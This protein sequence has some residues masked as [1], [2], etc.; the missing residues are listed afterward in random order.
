[1]KAKRILSFIL[2]S[3]CLLTLIAPSVGAMTITVP[4]Y[5]NI[6]LGK[7]YTTP[8][9]YTENPPR[10]DY[11][12]VDGKELTDGLLGEGSDYGNDWLGFTVALTGGR[13]HVLTIDMGE[14][15]SGITRLNIVAQDNSGSG[16]G[17]PSKIEY[18]VSND[19]VTYTKL[20]NAEI[21]KTTANYNCE[22]ILN[23]PVSG[24]YFRANV[25]HSNNFFVFISEFE[26]CQPDGTQE[27]EV[28][29]G[30][31]ETIRLVGNSTMF[32]D[33]DGDLRGGAQKMT[34]EDFSRNFTGGLNNITIVTADGKER[35]S[36]YVS[37]G[38][39]AIKKLDGKETD[40][41]TIIID[42]DVNGDG[43]IN[44]IDYIMVKRQVVGTYTIP[45]KSFKAAA[46]SD[47]SKVQTVDYIKVKRH[48]LN[49]YNIASQYERKAIFY[50]EDMTFTKVSDVLYRMDTTYQGKAYSQTFDKK[51]DYT[52]ESSYSGKNWGSWNIG[53]STYNGKALAGGGTD[54]EYVYRAS[55]KE[56]GGWVW[57]G[58]NHGNELFLSLE[59]YDA[60]TGAKKELKNGES[61]KTKGIKLVEKL[62]LHWG[63]PSKYYAEVTRT[64]YIAGTRIEL[65]V[66]YHYV[67]DSYFYMSYTCM[68]PIYKSFCGTDGGRAR[69]Y[70]TDGTYHESATTNGN[71]YAT[72]YGDHYDRGNKSLKTTF[73]SYA[74]KDWKYDVEVFTPYD[75]TDNFSNTAKT[76]LWD[77][78]RV[79]DKLYVS[80]FESSTSTKISAGSNVGTRSAWT[81]YV[82][83]EF[84]K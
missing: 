19:N 40:R 16:I 23:K 15:T 83:D 43:D 84:S 69:I 76:Q 9:A 51:S 35:K 67:R 38:D 20:G 7:S 29:D 58:G 18:E 24:R 22:L 25:A 78:N 75:S 11:M 77:M 61:F 12:I 52:P 17:L 14:V 3:M 66:D 44:V 48:V 70:A 30:E 53:T 1:M 63:D 54:W 33:N 2:L 28:P 50:D 59:V 32:V 60:V 6:A 39:I 42:G 79:S 5:K 47:G 34:V 4:K 37:T 41:A 49:T 10:E 72:E 82:S 31:P 13:T 81:F 65:D 36:G 26:V 68:F 74:N 45:G 62:H 71:V 57:S 64:Y 80:K 21:N 73:W 55:D 56:T 46:I 8:Q 27:I